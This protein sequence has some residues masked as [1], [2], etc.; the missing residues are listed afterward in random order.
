MKRAITLK[1][2]SNP[3][4]FQEPS[5]VVTVSIDPLSG[6]LAT[7]QC[8]KTTDAVYVA[9]SEPVT[10]CPLHG[11]KGA[12]TTVSGWDVSSTET[13]APAQGYITGLQPRRSGTN[14]PNPQAGANAAQPV[15]PAT[16]TKNPA[17]T[18][19]P[20]KKGLFDRLKGIFH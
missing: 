13:V 9:G 1:Q 8:P 4:P 3:R 12:S 19:E 16:V 6:M 18:Q 17:S 2:Y 10:Y 14:A 20:K 11:G 7:P 15:P 5:G